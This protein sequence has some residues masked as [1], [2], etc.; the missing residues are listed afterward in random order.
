MEG[1]KRHKESSIHWS[2]HFIIQAIN[3]I[4]TRAASL[5][6]LCEVLTLPQ[7]ALGTNLQSIRKRPIMTLAGDR[8]VPRCSC[9]PG[10]PVGGVT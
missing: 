2:R 3:L 4:Y 7:Q 6:Q 5:Q 9:P 10:N 1:I 8:G